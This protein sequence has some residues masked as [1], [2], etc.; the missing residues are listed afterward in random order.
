[1]NQELIDFANSLFEI[2]IGQGHR[3]ELEE[4]L[5]DVSKFQMVTSILESNLSFLRSKIFA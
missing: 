2:Q 4:W 1:M 5:N 3:T